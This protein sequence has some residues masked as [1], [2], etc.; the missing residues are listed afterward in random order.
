MYH[1]DRGM[2]PPRP[3]IY[4]PERRTEPHVGAT[5]LACSSVT[6]PADGQLGWSG[7]SLGRKD[8]DHGED[9]ADRHLVVCSGQKPVSRVL[10]CALVRL[11]RTQTAARRTPFCCLERIL[12][13]VPCVGLPPAVHLSKESDDDEGDHDCQLLK[14]L[15]ALYT[16]GD[17]SDVSRDPRFRLSDGQLR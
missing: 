13:P 12:T 10:G 5:L 6:V 16:C 9:H 8:D 14:G 15:H 1:W 3:E 7:A 17:S 11:S 2:G 4:S